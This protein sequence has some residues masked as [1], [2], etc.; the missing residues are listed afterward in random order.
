M[1][2]LVIFMALLQLTMI[3][4]G[5]GISVADHVAKIQERLIREQANFQLNDMG[6]LIEGDIQ[7]LLTILGKIYE[8]PFENGAVRVVTNITIDDRRDKKIHIGD[9]TNS[10]LKKITGVNR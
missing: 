5:E 10:V 8:V 7:H 9:K 1:K 3:P 4:M 6:T 2:N